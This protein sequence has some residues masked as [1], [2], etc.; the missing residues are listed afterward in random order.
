MYEFLFFKQTTSK[1]PYRHSSERHHRCPRPQ[2]SPAKPIH[3]SAKQSERTRK[4]SHTE[5][6]VES[7]LVDIGPLIASSRKTSSI[8][9][10]ANDRNAFFYAYDR[11]NKWIEAYFFCPYFFVPGKPSF[12][13]VL[14]YAAPRNIHITACCCIST[15][16]VLTESDFFFFFDTYV[17]L[18]SLGFGIARI[19]FLG[20]SPGAGS[21]YLHL[22]IVFF[23]S[24]L[25]SHV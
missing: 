22:G 8:V 14:H 10:N 25:C 11:L 1:K 4:Y 23:S 13:G 18:T 15:S 17:L 5:W 16:C 6:K 12:E 7:A 3:R 20:G 24:R 19:R 21:R 2:T 9:C